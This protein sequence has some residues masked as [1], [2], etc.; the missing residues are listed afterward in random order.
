[1]FFSSFA[2]IFLARAGLIPDVETATDK[3]PRRKE[4]GMIKSDGSESSTTFTRL[5]FFFDL[6]PPCD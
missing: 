5:P 4:E 3:S 1:M 2:R 6:Q